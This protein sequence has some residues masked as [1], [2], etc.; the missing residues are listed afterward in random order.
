M[1]RSHILFVNLYGVATEAIKNV[2]LAGVGKVTILDAGVVEPADLSA[3]F[4]VRE[5]DVGLDVSSGC[6]ALQRLLPCPSP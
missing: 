4:F 5:E 3:G 2:V 1:R 6:R